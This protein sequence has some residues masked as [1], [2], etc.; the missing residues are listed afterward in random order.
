MIPHMA[1]EILWEAP[2]SEEKLPVRA[3]EAV[4]ASY[5]E[6]AMNS[7]MKLHE[8][9]MGE[10][11]RRVELMRATFE[12]DRA[13]AERDRTIAALRAQVEALKRELERMRQWKQPRPGVKP[14]APVQ[15]AAPPPPVPPRPVNTGDTERSVPGEPVALR[16]VLSVSPVLTG[17]PDPA[18]WKAW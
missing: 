16:A 4:P 10:K 8:E 3:A 18:G 11:E 12:R 15:R 2:T 17:R 1:A 6:R 7:L 13:V 5:A 14:P 9:L